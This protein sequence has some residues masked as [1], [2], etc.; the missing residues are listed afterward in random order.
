VQGKQENDAAS[1]LQN[2]GFTV[3][4]QQDTASTQPA[5]LVVG[6]NPQPG[7]QVPPGSVVTISV[8]GASSVPTVVGLSQASAE[9]LLQS[10]GFKVTV[11][12]VPGPA[13]TQPGNVWQQTPNANVTAAQG[14][15]VTILVQPAAATPSGSPSAPASPTDGGSPPAGGG[16]N[17]NGNGGNGF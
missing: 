17:G 12:P 13:G 8:S 2:Q 10:R 7:T 6:Q 14:T 9:A 3:R 16:G 15:T 11:D 1:T 4:I 5:G